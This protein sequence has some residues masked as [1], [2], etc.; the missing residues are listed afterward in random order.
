MTTITI[1]TTRICGYCVMAK[2]LMDSKGLDYSEI[3]VSR[4]TE[5]RVWLL[6][7]TGRRTVPQIFFDDQP[8]G[9]YTEL[10]ALNRDGAL[11]ALVTQD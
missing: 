1:Y 5:K 3:D 6:E 11:D 10:A 7:Q 2:R 9:G 8:I 4:D